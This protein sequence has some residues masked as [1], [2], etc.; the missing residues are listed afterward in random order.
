MEFPRNES[1]QNE[2]QWCAR[3]VCEEEPPSLVEKL[4]LLWDECG[5]GPVDES[6]GL[7]G[8]VGAGLIE[9][10]LKCP[11]L[12]VVFLPGIHKSILGL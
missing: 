10:S 7:L 3:V 11:G 12:E 4:D 1:S 2:H 9:I 6:G 5:G 8:T